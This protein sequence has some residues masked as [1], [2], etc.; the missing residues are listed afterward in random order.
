[1]SEYIPNVSVGVV[2]ITLP[3]FN[4]AVI[5]KNLLA[6][7][8]FITW[9]AFDWG[10]KAMLAKA[11]SKVEQG[12]RLTAQSTRD[13]VLIDLHKQINKLTESRQL[14]ETA[15]LARAAARERMRVSTNRYKYTAEKLS[16]VLQAQSGLADENNNYHQAL[17]SFWEAKAQF[18]R[19]VGSE[20]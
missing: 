4:N 16:E 13:L 8:I 6:P 1:M 9:D 5:S 17:L 18:E 19:A 3:G 12:A 15:Q 14:V 10:H 11:H 2:Y 20:R 7:G